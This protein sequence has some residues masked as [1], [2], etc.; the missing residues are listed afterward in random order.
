MIGHTLKHIEKLHS[1]VQGEKI[2]RKRRR[3]RLRKQIVQATQ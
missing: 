2:E 1:V 3:G